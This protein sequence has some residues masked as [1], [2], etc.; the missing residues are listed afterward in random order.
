[1]VDGNVR[2][3]F[4]F[5]SGVGSLLIDHVAVNDGNWHH[6]HITRLR[7][8][9]K[10]SLDNHFSSDGSGLGTSA[11]ININGQG[12]VFGAGLSDGGEWLILL[13]QMGVG[14]FEGILI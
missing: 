4:D 2:A 7:N 6:V 3:R 13:G 5:G 11:R 1:M 9:V 14:H 10:L 8:Y 12:I